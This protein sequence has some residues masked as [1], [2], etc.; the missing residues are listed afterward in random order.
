MAYVKPTITDFNNT[1]PELLGIVPNAQLTIAIDQAARSVDETWVE[2]DFANAIL[3]LTA[4]NLVA[5]K[6]STA[7][8][9]ISSESFGPIS[10]SYSK[11]AGDPLAATSYGAR[12]LELLNLN[13]GAPVLIV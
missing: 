9:D 12:Y 13:H 10:V 1:F 11:V 4:H 6:E 2:A 3:F 8:G 5:A 7:G